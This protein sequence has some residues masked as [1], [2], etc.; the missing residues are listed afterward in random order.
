MNL[1]C[2]VR[3]PAGNLAYEAAHRRFRY[4]M[5]Q[6]RIPY[7]TENSDR[8]A[9]PTVNCDLRP[10]WFEAQRCD[11]ELGVHRRKQRCLAH[12]VPLYPDKGGEAL[13]DRFADVNYHIPADVQAG[14]PNVEAILEP[15]SFSDGARGGR[16]ENTVPRFHKSIEHIGRASIHVVIEIKFTF[17]AAASTSAATVAPTSGCPGNHPEV[18]T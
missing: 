10:R 7:G 6:H 16:L 1:R 18:R 3:E 17:Q 11:F 15:V 4:S 8:G 12:G 2:L 5:T 14:H 13:V 9:V